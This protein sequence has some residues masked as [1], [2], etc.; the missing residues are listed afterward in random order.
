MERSGGFSIISKRDAESMHEARNEIETLGRRRSLFMK[1]WLSCSLLVLITIA[2]IANSTVLFGASNVVSQYGQL[3]IAGGKLCSSGGAAIQLKGM[4]SMGLQWY[5]F[6]SS[7]VTNLVNDWKITVV[8]AA[9]YTAENGY[10]ADPATMKD[11]VKTIV[12]AAISN[13]IYVIIDWHILTDGNPNT[14][15]E[16]ARAF[17]DEMSKTFGS[18]PNVLYEICNEPN[19]TDWATIKSYADYVIPTIRANDPDNIIICGTDTWSQGVLNAANSPLSYSNVMYAL[20]FYAGTHGAS[21]RS[22]ADS[23]LAKGIAIFVTE[24]GTSDASGSGGVFLTQA[25][26]WVTWMNNNKLSWCNWSL[27]P[28][29]ETSAALLPGTSM[30]GPW[31]DS[32]LSESGKWVKSKLLEGATNPTPT[33][34]RTPTPVITAVRTATPVRTTTP[35]PTVTPVRTVTPAGATPTPV[36]AGGIK[37]QMFNANT[38]ASVNTLNPQFR[39]VNTGS[40]AI[41]LS[42]IKVRYYYTIDGEKS[43]NFFVDYA[44]AGSGNIT[45][46]FVKM[47]TAKTN[48]D[49]YVEIGFNSAGSLA[50]G[51]SSDI[52]CRIAK[53]D[54][55]NYTQAND[56]SFNA[57]STTYADWGKAPGYIAGSLKWGNEP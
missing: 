51:A 14:Y 17:F 38:A 39:I 41:A 49:Y 3:K 56:Y 54:W 32:S 43:Q 7:T 18:Y 48:A 55:S 25:Q 24:W 50:A 31:A 28:K 42:S 4:S 11:R 37:V 5:P 8:R 29:S 57:S 23:A 44:T 46:T 1:K 22:N 52:Q 19:G 20:H 15:K 45:G 12:N 2:L 47:A 27:C 30:D 33:P 36:T 21:L 10:I 26:E 6:T 35:R 40:S 13:G 53:A 9:M 34:A 16:Q